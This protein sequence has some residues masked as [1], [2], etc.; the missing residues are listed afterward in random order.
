MM[1]VL[2]GM[3]LGRNFIVWSSCSGKQ[4]EKQTP[5]CAQSIAV[6]FQ[7]YVDQYVTHVTVGQLVGGLDVFYKDSRNRKILTVNAIWIVLNEI[8][9]TPRSTID[10][11]IENSRK[12]AND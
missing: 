2:D 3:N 1:G 7:E 8:A 12:H 9:G 6:S 11:L 10:T 5:D 4:P